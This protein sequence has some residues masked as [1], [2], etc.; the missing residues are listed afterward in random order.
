[1]KNKL[2][3][4]LPCYNEQEVLLETAKILKNK[5]EIL[6]KKNKISKDSKICFV[7]DGST[8]KTW[9]IICNLNKKNDMFTGIILSSNRGHQNALLAGLM[10][11]KNKADMVISMDADLQDDVD[12]IDDMIDKYL[13]G[14]DIVYGIRENRK[15]DSF[16]KR[17]SAEA[18]YKFMNALGAKTIFNHA[19]FRLM[20]RRSIAALEQF[21]EVNLF[22][23]GI[24]PMI[25][26]K[27]DYV[28]YSRK[29]RE[30]GESKYPLSKMLSLAFN[31]IT[32]FSIKLIRIISLIGVLSLILSF[33]MLVYSLYRLV[34]GE[35][36]S[37]W[38]SIIV[39]LWAIGGLILISIGIVGE[40]IGKIYMETK[41]RP[42]FIIQQ[43]LD[44]DKFE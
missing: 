16:L 2:Y 37:G 12:A 1:M 35:V 7:N 3:V 13:N 23:R 4:V 24:V 21:K 36:V 38:T 31:G 44:K 28:Y 11:S 29:K 17:A 43:D 40:Y 14:V 41:Q 25:G 9:E 8:D 20:S 39:S 22:L 32:S 34:T 33:G 30:L 5:L 10:S 27:S 42:R 26:F 15:S 19:D 6:M 18:F